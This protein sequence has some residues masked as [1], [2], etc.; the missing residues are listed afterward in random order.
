MTTR[1][2]SAGAALNRP[3]ASVSALKNSGSSDLMDYGIK[4]ISDEFG[5]KIAKLIQGD[6]E[7]DPMGAAQAMSYLALSH[8]PIRKAL[9]K[10]GLH[11][12]GYAVL[13]S[14]GTRSSSTSSTALGQ[15]LNVYV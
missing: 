11:P 12:D 14:P 1:D 10:T 13:I 6:A 9:A 3:S 2:L 5:T 15:L 7:K 4:A 8:P